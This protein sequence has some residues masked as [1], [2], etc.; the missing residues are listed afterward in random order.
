MANTIKMGPATP[1]QHAQSTGGDQTH[2]PDGTIYQATSLG[3][4][5]AGPLGT[6][7]QGPIPAQPGSQEIT[8][9]EEYGFTGHGAPGSGIGQ[10]HYSSFTDTSYPSV[11]DVEFSGESGAQRQEPQ[12]VPLDWNTVGKY[13]YPEYPMSAPKQ[14]IAEGVQNVLPLT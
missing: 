11:P 9:R 12:G 2:M 10:G 4:V 6:Y 8:P 14:K 7:A 5:P 13:R 3:P 1:D